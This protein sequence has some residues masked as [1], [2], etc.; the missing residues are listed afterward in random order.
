M[1]LLSPARRWL[2]RNISA[3]RFIQL[4]SFAFGL[5]GPL[6][7]L[8]TFTLWLPK[9]QA[10]EIAPY[11][12]AAWAVYGAYTLYLHLQ[13]RWSIGHLSG[14]S[15]ACVSLAAAAF[16]LAGFT[17]GGPCPIPGATSSGGASGGAPPSADATACTFEDDPAPLFFSFIILSVTAGPNVATSGFPVLAR[18]AWAFF[19]VPAA[20]LLASGVWLHPLSHFLQVNYNA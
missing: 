20:W 13:T 10:V 19:V 12:T 3:A 4:V 5:L 9:Y 16:V 14:V 2:H 18:H 1:G 11:F 6:I 15:A 17:H 8:L 7:F